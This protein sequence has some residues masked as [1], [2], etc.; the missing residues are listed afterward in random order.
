MARVC[1]PA[2]LA[3]CQ[4]LFLS[5]S[6]VQI[7]FHWESL[8]SPPDCHHFCHLYWASLFFL[9]GSGTQY[10]FSSIYS[11]S[12]SLNL[13]IFSL[14]FYFK[15]EIASLI[16]QRMCSQKCNLFHGGIP[17]VFFYFLPLSCLL[18]FFVSCCIFFLDTSGPVSNVF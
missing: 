10:L 7:T 2:H 14:S 4:L 12:L 9:V 11:I 16:S 6:F 1:S 15:E 18:F 5:F 13:Y 3:S 8:S 17:L